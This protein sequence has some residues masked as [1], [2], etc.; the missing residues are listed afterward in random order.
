MQVLEAQDVNKRISMPDLIEA[1]DEVFRAE[2][3]QP[4]RQI[5]S[6]PGAPGRLLLVMPA[7]SGNGAG[8]IK[9]ASVFPDNA[10]NGLP[11][12]QGKI[13][14]FSES[15]TPT[16]LIDGATV[17]KLRTSAASALASR[18]LSRADSRTLLIIGTGGLAPYMALAHS[19]VRP[20]SSVRVWG[21]CRRKV[22]DTIAEIR[23]LVGDA[24][25][26]V[27]ARNLANELPEA[28]IVSCA[29]S[30]VEPLVHGELLKSG[31][32]LDLVGSFWPDRREC[33]D[34]AII[35]ASV[36]VDTREGVLAEAG[37]ILI[38]LRSGVFTEAG[39]MGS[40]ADLSSGRS[41][42]RSAED[43]ITLFKSVG[44]AIEVTCSPKLYQ[45]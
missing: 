27:P 28:D 1:L 5:V 7:F 33:D 17:T 23:K 35:R 38:P 42:G 10:A 18:Y 40:L 31:S 29:T 15:G 16:A 13:L 11:T 32:F 24:L 25:E 39:I 44:S 9:L 14:V 2:T 8:I 34:E 30:T 45:S 4:D 12:I 6:V 37:D 41:L 19:T 22:A 43:E 21:R 26:V 3:S 20:I 36:Y